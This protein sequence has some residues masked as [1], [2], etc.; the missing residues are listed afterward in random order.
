[1][2]RPRRAR[3][4][5]RPGS[6]LAPRARRGQARPRPR[7]EAAGRHV[8]SYEPSSL[9]SQRKLEVVLGRE[10]D[11]EVVRSEAVPEVLALA[12][13]DLRPEED[14]RRRVIQDVG[15]RV[16]PLLERVVRLRVAVV[17]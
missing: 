7:P 1:S 15:E 6:A 8:P 5:S 13:L 2:R 17:D 12:P 10:L 4:G 16:L 9:A 14:G 3:P 11:P